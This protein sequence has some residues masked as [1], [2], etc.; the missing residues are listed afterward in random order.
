MSISDRHT[1]DPALGRF[2]GKPTD[3][4]L[5]IRKRTR[6][7]P[8]LLAIVGVLVIGIA[9]IAFGIVRFG[10]ST[11]VLQNSGTTASPTENL[12]P[13]PNKS[14][15]QAM[16]KNPAPETGPAPSQAPPNATTPPQ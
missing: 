12:L 6:P 2:G 9:L 16:G 10:Q 4:S 1:E 11:S 3:R 14:P 15:D 8:Y 7:G 13:E 5:P